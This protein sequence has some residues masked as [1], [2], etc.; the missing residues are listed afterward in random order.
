MTKRGKFIA[1]IC[2][3]L[4]V[5][6]TAGISAAIATS[7]LGSQSDPLV[8]KSYLDQTVKPALTTQLNKD[9]DTAVKELTADFDQKLSGTGS[10]G[11]TFTLVTLSSGQTLT[12]SA[13]TE[14]MLRIGTAVTAGP[15]YPRLINT[16]TG[17]SVG[18]AGTGLTA[19]HLYMCTIAGNGITATAGTTKLLVRGAYTIG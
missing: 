15:D 5:V 1:A 8:T 10:G 19:N 9:I 7:S 12:C 2:V 13:G 18:S 16:T 3:L 11:N 4:L 6:F 14:L 17:E